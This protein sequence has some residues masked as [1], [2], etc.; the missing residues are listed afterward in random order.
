MYKIY[1]HFLDS[2]ATSGPMCVLDK[3]LG[4]TFVTFKIEMRR[5]GFLRTLYQGKDDNVYVV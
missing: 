1:F 5:L 2:A 4:F 3:P